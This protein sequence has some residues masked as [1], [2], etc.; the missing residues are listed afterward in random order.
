[1]A[2]NLNEY[3]SSVF[4][5]EYINVLPVPETKFE[6]RESYYLGHLIVTPKRVAKKISKII[7]QLEWMGFLPNYC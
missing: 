4:T 1:M 2:E 3:F 7:N 5:R 6:M